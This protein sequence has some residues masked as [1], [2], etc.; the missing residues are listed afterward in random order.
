MYASIEEW[1]A[2]Q[3]GFAIRA[4]RVPEGAMTWI[5]EAAK[6]ERERCA[7]E[8]E[9]LRTELDQVRAAV[10]SAVPEFAPGP[11]ICGKGGE[12]RNGLPDRLHVC[13]SYGVDWIAIYQRIEPAS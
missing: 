13:P 12:E 9:R 4:E 10:R 1:L 2:E 5:I 7:A 3:E 6:V 11:F 8:I